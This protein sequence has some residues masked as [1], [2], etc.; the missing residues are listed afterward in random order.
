MALHTILG[1]GGAIASELVP[2]LQ[3]H[4]EPLR[5]VSRGGRPTPGAD[6]VAADITDLGATMEA[7]KGSSVVY[8]LAGLPYDIRVWR[9][10]WPKIMSN[11]IEACK[12]ASTRLLFFDNVYMLWPRT[13][14]HDRGRPLRSRSA[15]RRACV[16]YR[17][18]TSGRDPV[19][20]CHRPYRKERRFL[21]PTGPD[22]C[23]EHAGL[24]QTWR[25]GKKG[26]VVC[27]ADVLTH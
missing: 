12:A 19:R 26:A 4:N 15:G 9:V 13:W 25:M 21:R 22:E 16:R 6:M 8:L 3:A 5:L 1:A 17:A 18:A 7:V 2:I 10:Q 14:T 11:V 27:N 20:E 23:V 24:R